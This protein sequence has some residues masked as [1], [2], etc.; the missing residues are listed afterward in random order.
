M[1]CGVTGV[2][3]IQWRSPQDRRNLRLSFGVSLILHSVGLVAWILLA[4]AMLTLNQA[5][6][7]DLQ[8]ARERA[9]ASQV[10]TIFVEVNPE[11]ATAEAPPETPFYSTANTRAANPEPDK[12]TGTPKIAGSQEE[13]LRTQE[14]LRPE[15]EPLQPTPPTT[16]P[17]DAPEPIPSQ[18]QATGDLAVT[19]DPSTSQTDR[20][21]RAR[22]LTEARLN[23]GILVGPKSRQ[24]GGVRQRGALSLD[25]KG[26]PFGAYDAALIAAIQQH[27]YDLIEGNLSKSALRSG[28]VV[29]TFTLHADGRVDNVEIR[30]QEAGEI[31]ALVCSKAIKDPAP[32]AKWP[33]RMRTEL[34][35]DYRELRITFHYY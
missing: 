22:T 21:P 34:G 30:Q 1:V 12:D 13:S 24:E 2:D 23:K 11:Q 14:V 26:S 10:P 20:P 32:Y 25:A 35:R 6:L 18:A 3:S 27:W 16:E 7:R 4:T 28:R 19:P 33:D 17:T 29:I 8:A 31:Q 15:P 5:L 9:R